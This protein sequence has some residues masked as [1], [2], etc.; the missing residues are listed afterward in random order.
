M[1]KSDK[2]FRKLQLFSAAV[3]SLAHGM[4]DAQKT[5]GIIAMALFS[6]GLLGAIPFIFPFGLSSPATR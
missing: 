2:L 3:Y 4:N 6:K 5:M 1:A